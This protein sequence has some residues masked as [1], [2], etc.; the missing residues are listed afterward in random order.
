MYTASFCIKLTDTEVIW[1]DRASINKMP[2]P[3]WPV[4]NLGYIFLTSY[5]CGR[6]RPT[7][8]PVV[9]NYISK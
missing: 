7:T 1:K 5:C 2:P 8:G 9:L 4:G 3:D 6:I